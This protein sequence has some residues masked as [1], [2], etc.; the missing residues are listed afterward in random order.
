MLYLFTLFLSPLLGCVPIFEFRK[1]VNSFL[2]IFVSI[3]IL[4]Y[5]V[6]LL[7]HIF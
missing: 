3:T 6:I 7:Y 4:K 1:I 5:L 2:N